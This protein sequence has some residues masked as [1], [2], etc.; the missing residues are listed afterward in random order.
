LIAAQPYIGTEAGQ[1]YRYSPPPTATALPTATP[2]PTAQPALATD[3][4]SAVAAHVRTTRLIAGTLLLALASILVFSE[5]RRQRDQE[6][7]L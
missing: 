7:V 6:P 1:I 3:Q 4:P 5:I 2:R